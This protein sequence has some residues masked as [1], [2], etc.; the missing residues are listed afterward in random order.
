MTLS[1]HPEPCPD[2][3]PLW[4]EEIR[5]TVRRFARRGRRR[6]TASVRSV[7]GP[8]SLDPDR[9][10]WSAFAEL[11]WGQTPPADFCNNY[12]VRALSPSSHDPRRD[13]RRDVLPFLTHHARPSRL[14]RVRSG[15]ARRAAQRPLDSAPVPVPPGFRQVCPTAIPIRVRHPRRLATTKLQWRSTCTGQGT[16]RRTRRP[17]NRERATASRDRCMPFE[18][19]MRTSFPSSATPGHPLS[20]V[21]H[22]EGEETPPEGRTDQD[23]RSDVVPRRTPPSGRPGCLPPFAPAGPSTWIAPHRLPAS[24]SRSRRPHVLPRLGRGA[25]TGLASTTVRSPAIHGIR[26]TSAF[27][28][29]WTA[30]AWD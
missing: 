22:S 2:L 7:L 27:A 16:K 28:T 13:G 8:R 19:R 23:P 1:R 26:E 12:D 11:I 5:V 29:R 9:S 24:V 17:P 6:V 21:R 30:R 25:F 4:S 20:A 10:F 15:D 18:E 14:V 3:S